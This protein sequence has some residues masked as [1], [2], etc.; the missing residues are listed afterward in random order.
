M[1][2]HITDITFLAAGIVLFAFAQPSFWVADGLPVLSYFALIPIFILVNRAGFKTIWLYGILFGVGYYC[3]FTGWLATFHPMG[4]TVISC[5]YGVQFML[6]FPLLK[7]AGLL[8]HKQRFFVQWI[9]WC[10]YEYVKTKGFA[11]FNYGV[12]AYSHWRIIPLIQCADLIGVW[13]LSALITFVSAWWAQVLFPLFDADKT[14]AVSIKQSI[15]LHRVSAGIWL[16][17]FAL[18]WLYGY[19]ARFDYSAFETKKIILVQTNTDPWIGGTQAYRRDLHTLKKLTDKAL[20]E[21]GDAAL[22][23]WPETAFIPR[24]RWHYRFR[25][26]RERFDLVD[27]LLHYI[28]EKSV[29]F[30]IGND[31]TVLDYSADGNYGE[32]SYNAVLL[33]RPKQNVIPPEPELYH[34]MHLVPFTEHFPFEKLFPHIYTLLL[35]GDTHMWTPGKRVH[36][37]SVEGLRFGTPVCFEDTFGY[38]GRRYVKN[39]ANALVNLSNDAWSKSLACQY[40]HLSMAV[41]RAVENR[42]PLVRATASGQTVF[43]DPNGKVTAMLEP[44]TEGF[45]AGS[46]P[47]LTKQRKTMYTL[48]G[49]YTGIAF[50]VCAVCLFITGIARFFYRRMLCRFHTDKNK[51]I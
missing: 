34:K 17:L 51:A 12:T 42:L 11:G 35:N 18:C 43:V 7:A 16:F 37:F 19:T 23:V 25:T 10:A 36:V 50:T 2:K 15:R 26:D 27:E 14:A 28:N 13:G 33:F 20:K 21:H 32:V 6:L 24:I 4:L 9:V 39:G 5:L 40:Q 29:P 41:F 38:I 3:L 46:I 48:L 31:D 30:V 22:V 44:F 8:W 49:D 1:K 45:L 47:V